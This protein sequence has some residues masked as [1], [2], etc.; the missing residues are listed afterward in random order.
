MTDSKVYQLMDISNEVSKDHRQSILRWVTSL[1]A[2]Y[3][4]VAFGMLF[5]SQSIAEDS[6][7][8][9]WYLCVAF[10]IS[11]GWLLLSSYIVCRDVYHPYFLF[12]LS[13]VLFNGVQLILTGI[14]LLTSNQIVYGRFS[15][16]SSRFIS[17]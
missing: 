4:A 9:T 12:L 11:A 13:A 2:A 10:T 8:Y 14:G 16:E 6:A 3:T 1:H 15:V 17:L 7:K 5:V